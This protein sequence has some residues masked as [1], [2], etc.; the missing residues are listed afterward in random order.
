MDFY[1]FLRT[2]NYNRSNG[3]INERVT[4]GNWWST[5]AGSATNGHNLNTNPT[6]VNPQNNNYRGNGFAVRCVVLPAPLTCPHILYICFRRRTSLTSMLS[7][8]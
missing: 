3:N 8:S 4:N 6:N 2:G 5:T 1:Y 7:K